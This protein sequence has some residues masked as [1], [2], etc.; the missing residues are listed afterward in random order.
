MHL[1]IN[2]FLDG[3]GSYPP[4]QSPLNGILVGPNGP[5]G[6]YGR[7]YNPY[8]QHGFQQHGHGHNQFGGFPNFG[9]EGQHNGLGPYSG[10]F[11]PQFGGGSFGSNFG[12]QFDSGSNGK[13]SAVK[14][15]VEKSAK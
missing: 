5:T 3:F 2:E 10:Q 13:N 1:F 12:P 6:H 9:F 15:K 7:P 11:N 4:H 8:N 14:N